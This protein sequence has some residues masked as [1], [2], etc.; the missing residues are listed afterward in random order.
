MGKGVDLFSI[1][2]RVWR[3]T[4]DSK[5]FLFWPARLP[6]GYRA[7]EGPSREAREA[8]LNHSRRLT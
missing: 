3:N 6:R 5:I 2:E 1:V 7:R 4:E 8:V